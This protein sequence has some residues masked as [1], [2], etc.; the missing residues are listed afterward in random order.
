MTRATRHRLYKSESKGS[1]GIPLDVTHLVICAS[2][3][4]LLPSTDISHFT[5]NNHCLQN[6][7]H[8][9]TRYHSLLANNC[10]MPANK[11]SINQKSRFNITF[12]RRKIK[13]PEMG[14]KVLL[15]GAQASTWCNVTFPFTKLYSFVIIRAMQEYINIGKGITIK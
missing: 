8:L 5:L 12:Q 7:H 10:P 3:N 1:A 11:R 15:K 14:C 2:R 6:V 9:A 13:E 4:L